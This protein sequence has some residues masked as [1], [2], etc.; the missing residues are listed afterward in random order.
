M[1][2]TP[3]LVAAVCIL[4][5]VAGKAWAG[6]EHAERFRVVD[7]AGVIDNL[8]GLMW[9]ARDNGQD[10]NWQEAKAYCENYRAGNHTDW[11]QPTQEE[12][13]TLFQPDAVNRQGY[14]ITDH[15]ELSD[16]CPWASDW[17]MRSA[18]SFSFKSGRRPWAFEADSSQLRA[19]PV[20]DTRP[21]AQNMQESTPSTM[22]EHR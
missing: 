12:L 10:I 19:L 18:G 13:K 8:T 14:K 16:C 17:S 15:I 7:G 21:R 4:V 11:R 9:A 1:K 5:F 3:L 20:R 2:L 6:E 22:M